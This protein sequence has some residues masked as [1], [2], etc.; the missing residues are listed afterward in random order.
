MAIAGTKFL[1]GIP[2]WVDAAPSAYTKL[3]GA[4]AAGSLASQ[5]RQ[6]G[7]SGLFNL[8]GVMVFDGPEGLENLEGGRSLL[9]WVKGGLNGTL[10][11]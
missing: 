1:I 11:G 5:L 6:L 3:G 7:L 4:Q 8:G 9:G 2:A 10:T